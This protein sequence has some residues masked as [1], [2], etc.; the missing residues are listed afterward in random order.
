[1]TFRRKRTR[2]LEKNVSCRYVLSSRTCAGKVGVVMLSDDR[3]NRE[4][5]VEMG[6]PTF[7]VA[8]F[9]KNMPDFPSLADK[10]KLKDSADSGYGK[11]FLF[12]E[13]LSS[14]QVHH[15]GFFNL[16]SFCSDS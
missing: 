3:R 13:H 9:V 8:E 15:T 16:I 6:I 5:A 2:S 14:S 1:M 12:P 4:L 10:L 7:A 11:K